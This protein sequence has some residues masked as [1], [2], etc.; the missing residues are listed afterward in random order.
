MSSQAAKNQY[1]VIVPDFEGALQ[2][3]IDVRPQHFKD[4]RPKLDDGTITFGGALLTHHPDPSSANSGAPPPMKAS[5]VVVT[6]ASE[7]EVKAI[8]EADVYGK[9]GVW[10]VANAQIMPFKTAVQTEIP[11]PTLK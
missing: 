5:A 1:L 2:K 3:R 7:A 9:S 8:L 6:A 11:M 4:L 10:D